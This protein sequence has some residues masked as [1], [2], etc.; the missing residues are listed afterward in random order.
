MIVLGIDPGT[1]TTG[2]GF[3][4]YERGQ[5]RILDYGC[6]KTASNLALEERLQQI[7]EDLEELINKWKPQS[8]AVE[9]IFFSKNVKTAISVAHARGV[10]LQK[11]YS[12]GISSQKYTPSQVKS[13][14]CGDGKADKKQMQKMIKILF[15]LEQEPKQ[16]DAAD[17][18]AIALCHIYLNKNIPVL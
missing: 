8:A 11:L 13:S 17:A 2:F 9:E 1:A 3:V 15:S 16:D 7:W 6:I 10:I 4:H 18:L 14:I 5:A 12:K